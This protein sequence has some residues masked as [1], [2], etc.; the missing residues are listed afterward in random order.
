MYKISHK[1]SLHSS[2]LPQSSHTLCP[3]VSVREDYR[4]FLFAVWETISF[5]SGQILS[6]PENAVL[7]SV[8]ERIQGLLSNGRIKW[9]PVLF[10]AMCWDVDF[11]LVF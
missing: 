9:K 1:T 7:Q 8:C 4:R 6:G 5:A 2:N 11:Y 10:E 3:F